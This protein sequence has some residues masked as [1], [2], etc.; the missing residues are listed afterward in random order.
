MET[1]ENSQVA[2]IEKSLDVLKTGPEI[3]ISNQARKE[4]ALAVGRNILAEIETEEE[5]QKIK[6]QN[7]TIDTGFVGI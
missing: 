7:Q 3:L 5:A 6:E 1:A 4:K 2:I